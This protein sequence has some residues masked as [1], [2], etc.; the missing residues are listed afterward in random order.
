MTEIIDNMPFDEYVKA[1]GINASPIKKGVDTMFQMRHYLTAPDTSNKVMDWGRKAHVWVLQYEQRWELCA[2]YNGALKGKGS[3]TELKAFTKANEGKEILKPAEVTELDKMREV[4]YS[5]PWI[6]QMLDGAVKEVVI[7][8]EGTFGKGK[9]RMDLM[10]VDYI[11]DV[12]NVPTSALKSN[13]EPLAWQ[14]K[15]PPHLADI[16]LGWYRTGFMSKFE[17]KPKCGILAIQNKSPYDCGLYWMDDK[18]VDTGAERAHEIACL[19]K[20]C[21]LTGRYDGVQV[22]GAEVLYMPEKYKDDKEVDISNG[23]ME[24]SEL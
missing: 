18:W 8:W 1:E 22:D 13:P 10:G 20:A 24:A 23:E 3:Q 11:V 6:K 12:K 16:Q 15:K 14:M 9:C 19:Y 17:H 2:L 4:V 21:E 7:Q 5:K